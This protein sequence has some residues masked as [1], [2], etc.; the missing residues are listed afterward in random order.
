VQVDQTNLSGIVERYLCFQNMQFNNALKR[1]PK[2]VPDF[3][4]MGAE[5]VLHKLGN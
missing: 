5:R 1:T 4:E 2:W 3:H